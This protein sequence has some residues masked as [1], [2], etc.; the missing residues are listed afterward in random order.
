MLTPAGLGGI[1]VIR[2]R[3]G[4]ARKMA[5]EVF[6]NA[7]GV[8]P[9][10]LRFGKIISAGKVVDEAILACVND[11]E[12]EI[13]IH[14]GSAVGRLALETLAGCGCRISQHDDAA[15]EVRPAIFSRHPSFDNSAIG[16]EMLAI[17]PRICGEFALGVITSQWSA[18]L[19]ELLSGEFS[20]AELRAAAERF[21]IVRRLTDWPEVV[22]AGCPNAGKSTLA[23]TLVGRNVS[24]VHPMAGTT[25]DWVRE[26]AMILGR[27]V[28]LTDTA[29]LWD[30]A[31]LHDVDSQAVSRAWQQIR[32]AD[33]VLLAGCGGADIELPAEIPSA[34]V[35][36]IFTKADEF[37]PTRD[38][39]LS[40]SAL[41][42]QGIVELEKQI[43]N[44]L[45][46]D[47][48]FPGQPAAFTER[49]K[50]LLLK[51]AAALDAGQPSLCRQ[52]ITEIMRQ[53]CC[54]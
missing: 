53:T 18:G 44:R 24:I 1:A 35:L 30:A 43:L 29:G 2:L 16:A 54:D 22:I 48:I 45:G 3:G 31:G 47:K 23:N 15:V 38:D 40:V 21:D 19:S 42:G 34:R 25:R 32:Q 10:E 52:I 28:W 7:A 5:D 26:R 17:L 9:G 49:Q 33:L 6:S 20:A 8:A 27:P 46:L 41:T 51:S 12:F 39:I 14:G 37:T 13:N 11:D 50:K 36:K 4:M